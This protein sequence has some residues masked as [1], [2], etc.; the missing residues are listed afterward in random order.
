MLRV[1]YPAVLAVWSTACT[2]HLGQRWRKHG[3]CKDSRD[4]NLPEQPPQQGNLR[5]KAVAFAALS[6]IRWLDTDD[7]GETC[8]V[9]GV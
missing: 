1:V 9:A 8:E 7:S 6:N 4:H 3:V 5:L 2:S